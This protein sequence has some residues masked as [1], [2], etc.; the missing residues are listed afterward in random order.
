MAGED[1]PVPAVGNSIYQICELRSG[2][3]HGEFE[4]R[5]VQRLHYVHF[6]HNYEHDAPPTSIVVKVAIG[7][8]DNRQ[9]PA[10]RGTPSGIEAVQLQSAGRSADR[11]PALLGRPEVRNVRLQ[12]HCWLDWPALPGVRDLAGSDDDVAGDS[13]A[14]TSTSARSFKIPFVM[15]FVG[16]TVL[17]ARAPQ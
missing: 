17:S 14:T 9:P 2:F 3:G 10:L 1:D 8:G 5:H 6:V 4:G 13:R 15:I 7:H 11:K 12:R 16:T